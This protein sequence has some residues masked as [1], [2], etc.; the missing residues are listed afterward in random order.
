MTV[1][2]VFNPR[3]V[4]AELYN[5]IVTPTDVILRRGEGVDVMEVD[6][7]ILEEVDTTARVA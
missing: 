6:K 3:K 4:E 7:D 5:S 2:T 1:K